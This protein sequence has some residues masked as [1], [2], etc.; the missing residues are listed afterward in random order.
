MIGETGV[1]LKIAMVPKFKVDVM[2]WDTNVQF[3][4]IVMHLDPGPQLHE[5]LWLTVLDKTRKQICGVPSIAFFGW[6]TDNQGTNA[7]YICHSEERQTCFCAIDDFVHIEEQV[8]MIVMFVRQELMQQ[9]LTSDQQW[10]LP[11]VHPSIQQQARQHFQ[12]HQAGQLPEGGHQD[13]GHWGEDGQVRGSPYGIG[14][15]KSRRMGE[16]SISKDSDFAQHSSFRDMNEQKRS[17]LGGG[18]A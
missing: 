2:E 3:K 7:G 4:R 9:N 17:V 15:K 13:G 6:C 1:V 11:W 8:Q 18:G 5:D 10:Q 14:V 12:E 16:A